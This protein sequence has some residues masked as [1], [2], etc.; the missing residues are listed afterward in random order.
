M[1]EKTLSQSFYQEIIDFYGFDNNYSAANE[2][3]R[4]Y[5]ETRKKSAKD[6]Y[7]YFT[8][9]NFKDMLNQ[10]YNIS[11]ENTGEIQ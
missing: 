11:Q 2:V 5:F 1:F 4:L 9:E 10:I 7:D 6:F 3:H 8:S